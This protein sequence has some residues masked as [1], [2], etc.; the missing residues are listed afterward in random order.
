MNITTGF[1]SGVFDQLHEGHTFL[2]NEAK[3]YCNHLIVVINDDYYVK[4]H[5]GP[6]SPIDNETIRRK[7]LL[8]TGLVNECI[9]NIKETPISHIKKIKPDFIFVGD[10]YKLKNVIGHKECKSWGGK[11]VVIKRLPKISV[12][13]NLDR[14]TFNLGSVFDKINNVK[15]IVKGGF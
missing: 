11:V 9:I 10:D 13:E 1:I 2:L 12:T 15:A 4:K 7:R 14:Q 3:K 8:N 5:K 6:N